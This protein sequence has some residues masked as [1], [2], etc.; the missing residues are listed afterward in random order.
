M[1]DLRHQ[2]HV[3]HDLPCFYALQE[4]DNWTVADM[5]VPGYI[6]CGKNPGKTANLCP[7]DVN[8][9]RCSMGGEES[10]HRHFGG[11]EDASFSLHA[12]QWL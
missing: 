8:H 9:F 1:D 2:H 12:A 10:M 11:V 6:V 7:R 5:R 4:T 3:V